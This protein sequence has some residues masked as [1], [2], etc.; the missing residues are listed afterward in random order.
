M[1]APLRAA[2][3]TAVAAETAAARV[4]ARRHA[5]EPYAAGDVTVVVK[6]FERPATLRRMLASVRTV[7]AG[8]II[9]A[10]DSRHPVEL[11]LPGVRVLTLPFDS[12]IGA[13]RTALL[14][15]VETEF[16]LMCDDDFILLP[17]F[18]IA[19]AV[20]YLRRNPGVD[21]FGGRVLNLPDLTSTNYHH[22]ALLATR[23]VPRARQ[24]TLIDGLPVL[25]KVPNFYLAR[26]GSVR[27]VGYDPHLKRVDHNDFFTTAYGRIVCVQDRTWVC[28]HAQTLFD[29][30]Y[31][32]VRTDFSADLQYL[33]HKWGSVGAPGA[34]ARAASGVRLTA[35]QVRDFHLAAITRVAGDA[36]LG[37]AAL[38]A[39]AGEDAPR[40]C[41]PDV[42]RLRDA[43]VRAGWAGTRGGS[44]WHPLWG[45]AGLE[46]CEVPVGGQ[47]AA[48][49]L[50]RTTGLPVALAPAFSPLPAGWI[51]PS[52]RAAWAWHGDA[53]LGAVLPGGPVL[54]L[55]GPTARALEVIGE[56]GAPL[57]QV[58]TEVVASFP[59][60]PA[61]AVVSVRAA[62]TGL[63][64]AGLFTVT[65]DALRAPAG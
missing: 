65:G 59:D 33:A 52:A 20:G 51:A 30:H 9:V 57:E 54:E 28:L 1:R 41:T 18:D 63:T 22:Q 37:V 16:L 35:S 49:P 40:V 5:V 42:P 38:P 6:T 44:L 10:D 14:A 64:E 8:P 43:L 13:G 26:T 3:A 58:V 23:G 31:Q 25:Y 24:G 11:D 50:P 21:L 46:T 32:A 48:S 34:G 7:F 29:A 4:W 39:K 19:R 36:G 60:A 47:P 45:K 12:G 15:A 27:S 61:D 53:V 2:F 17:D 56:G 62:L 55:S